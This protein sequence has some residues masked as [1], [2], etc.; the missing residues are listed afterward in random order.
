MKTLPLCSFRTLAKT[1][2][3]LST[4]AVF[5]SACG[6]DNDK[7]QF[8]SVVVF[9]SSLSDVGSY[10]TG[11]IKAAGGGRST[12]NPGTIWVEHIAQRVGVGIKAGMVGFGTVSPAICPVQPCTGWAQGGARITNPNGGGKSQGLLTVPV[13]QQ[14]DLQLTQKAAYT[15]SDLI[16]V[17]AGPNDVYLLGDGVA[18]ATT[19]LVATGLSAAAAQA[20]ALANVDTGVK[21]AANELVD[22]IEKKLLAKGAQYVV[23][24]TADEITGTAFAARI[25]PTNT[26]L[27]SSWI[28]LLNDTVAAG[29]K[30]RNLNVLTIEASTFSQPILSDLPKNGFA[31]SKDPACDPAKI[32][33]NSGGL[34]R[35]GSAIICN[36]STLKAGVD[37]ATWLYADELHY[38]SRMHKLLADYVLAEMTKKGWF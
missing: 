23:M 11:A 27:V 12:I 6:S 37:A 16:I 10:E 1:A 22:A 20:Q 24:V 2:T 33:V 8:T 18:A 15:A 32:Q 4:V 5:L 7:P 9:G 35:D 26:A 36:A 19:N 29:I 38:A 17:A 13:V 25:G 31:N 34:I 21:A 3:V 30:A 28:K 14:M